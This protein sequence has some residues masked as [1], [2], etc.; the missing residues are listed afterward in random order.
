MTTKNKESYGVEE[1]RYNI[2]KKWKPELNRTHPRFHI[3]R[4]WQPEETLEIIR[5]LEGNIDEIA[6]KYSR[7]FEKKVPI[8]TFMETHEDYELGVKLNKL[9][10]LLTYESEDMDIKVGFDYTVKEQSM[11][12]GMMYDSIIKPGRRRIQVEM[13]ALEDAVSEEEFKEY[14]RMLTDMGFI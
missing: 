14:D 8:E 9:D 1:I 13:E 6:E 11:R 10:E 2:R 7:E 5:D 3:E 4:Y 12:F